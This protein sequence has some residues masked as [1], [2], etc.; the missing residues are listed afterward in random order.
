M[1]Y[2]TRPASLQGLTNGTGWD[3]ERED[4]DGQN[5]GEKNEK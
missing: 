5:E 2:L 1:C 3:Q 4:E